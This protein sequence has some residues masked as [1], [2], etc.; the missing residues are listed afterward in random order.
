MLGPRH[1]APRKSDRIW[2]A[3]RIGFARQIGFGTRYEEQDAAV[4]TTAN[5]SSHTRP[6]QAV[7]AAVKIDGCSKSNLLALGGANEFQAWGGAV[8]FN[9]DGTYDW[10]GGGYRTNAA[11]V[12]AMEDDK[13]IAS[14]SCQNSTLPAGR[15]ESLFF[16][17]RYGPSEAGTSNYVPGSLNTPFGQ[18]VAVVGDVDSNGQMD[19]AIGETE[20]EG[21]GRVWVVLLETDRTVKAY[22]QINSTT[23]LVQDGSL[24]IQLT[25]PVT[26]KF[27]FMVAGPGDVNGDGVPDLVV[28]A[29]DGGSSDTP[30][31]GEGVLYV[32]ALEASTARPLNV[33]RIFGI[34]TLRSLLHPDPA[35]GL[36]TRMAA[37]THPDSTGMFDPA[38]NANAAPP[39]RIAVATAREVLLM[40]LGPDPSA[41]GS[42]TSMAMLSVLAVA[43]STS[44]T[45]P[46]VAAVGDA[47]ADG[48]EDLVLGTA[49]PASARYNFFLCTLNNDGS[50][51]S[52]IRLR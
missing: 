14:T 10:L 31:S 17:R 30:A 18:S 49:N 1:P 3:N 42:T 45:Y 15:Q 7:T 35:G 48:V 29:P 40:D 32:F 51:Q 52:I 24:A 43:G 8:D 46:N 4:L 26:P 22:S 27:G 44:N 34:Q 39:R 47:N 6:F 37:L 2:R 25:D 11:L 50:T 33:L 41:T 19:L 16:A 38:T 36:G 23:R 28:S 21:H 20:F 5:A 12:L 9:N 13:D